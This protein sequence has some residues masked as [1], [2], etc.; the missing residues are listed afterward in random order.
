M[1]CLKFNINSLHFL[2]C[3]K[4]SDFLCFLH[5]LPFFFGGDKLLINIMPAFGVGIYKKQECVKT[6]LQILGKMCSFY[7]LQA[8]CKMLGKSN[9]FL[10]IHLCV[11]ARHQGTWILQQEKLT[12]NF[13]VEC[14]KTLSMK[15]KR[16]LW[17]WQNTTCQVL[18]AV[19]VKLWLTTVQSVQLKVSSLWPWNVW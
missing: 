9:P 2:F 4:L 5:Q 8:L 6:A 16:I 12:W 1:I 15:Y 13:P 19:M 11:V 18:V 17:T 14:K 7:V 3:M 10:P